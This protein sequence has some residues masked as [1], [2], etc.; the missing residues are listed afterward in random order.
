MFAMFGIGPSE[1]LF[2][3]LPAIIFVLPFWKIFTK[4]GFSG[5]LSIL[6]IIPFVNIGMLFFLAFTEWPALKKDQE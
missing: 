5:A 4:A 3:V 2:L 1:M 6:M